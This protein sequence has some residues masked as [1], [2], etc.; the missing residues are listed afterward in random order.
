V[1]FKL[2]S[3]P[4]A[5]NALEPY[6][7]SETI[8]F[9]Y[10]KHHQTYVNNLNNLLTNSPL[11]FNDIK[12]VIKASSGALFNNAA[13]VYNHSFYW[14]CMSSEKGSPGEKIKSLIER[15]FRSMDDFKQQFMTAAKTLFGSGW[16]WLVQTKDGAL[17]LRSTENAKTPITDNENPLLVCDV[18]EHAYYIDKRNDRV[19]YLENFWGIINWAF[20]EQ[21]LTDSF[22]IFSE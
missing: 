4:Y 14:N 6:I 18:W 2:N 5:K 8:D 10:G 13:Q 12:E 3:L 16:V 19:T 7:S 11:D 15:D 1:T 17:A 21:Q 22:N 20:V 9:H